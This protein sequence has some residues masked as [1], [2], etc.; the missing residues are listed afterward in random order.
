MILFKIAATDGKLDV[1]EWGDDSGYDLKHLL[2]EDTIAGTALNGHLAVVQ[3]LRT[4]G[5]SWNSGTC[6]NAALNG[7][8]ELLKWA[9]V[10]GCPW[11]E[12]TC[13]NAAG[14][15][16]LEFLKWARVNGCPWDDRTYVM[17]N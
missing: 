8:I 12:W 4:L 13:A 1:L 14:N 17:E 2:N 5:V 7:H 11:D 15:G 16:H 10:N 3:Y 6:T 9:W